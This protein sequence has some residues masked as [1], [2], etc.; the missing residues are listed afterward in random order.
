MTRAVCVCVPARD[1]AQHIAMLIDALA[2]Q[3]IEQPVLLALCVNNSR[4]DTLAIA[5]A[6]AAASHGRVVLDAVEHE[7]SGALAHVGSAR[8]A[9][10]ALGVDRIGDDGLLIST[11]ADC[12]PPPGWIAANI[13]ASAARDDL[14]I[15]GR[16]ELDDRDAAPAAVFALK[17]RFDSY[18]QKVREIE[19]KTDPQPWDPAPRHGDHTGASLAM[20]A[21]LYRRAGGVPLLATG[22][23]RALVEAAIAVGGK[24]VHPPAVWTRVSARTTGRAAGGMARDMQQWIDAIERDHVPLVPAFDHWRERVRWRRRMR[25]SH[26]DVARAERALPAMPCDMALPEL[27]RQ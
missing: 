2:T 22:E 17:R 24:L 23:D 4:D 26:A 3:T 20:G 25:A 1:E 14:I 8:R 11:D 7:F 18:W 5:R 9:A 19:D 16:I 12:R 13:A 6:A 27:Q 21:A 10:M 15:G